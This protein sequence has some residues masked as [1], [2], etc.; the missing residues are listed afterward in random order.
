L[1]AAACWRTTIG[2]DLGDGTHVIGLAIRVAQGDRPLADEMNL[3]VLG[4]LPSVPFTW[5]WLHVVGTEGIVLASRLFYVLFATACAVVAWRAL[6]P[7]FG[8]AVP[9]VAVMAAAIPAPYNLTVVSYN[10]TP[11]SLLLVAASSGCAAVLARSRL[12]AVVSGVT[13]VLAAVAYPVM[14]VAALFTVVLVLMLSRSRVVIVPCLAG[15][16]V[17]VG[18]VWVWLA[19][20]VGLGAV[21]ST[22]DF[23]N[24]YQAQRI[25]HATRLNNALEFMGATMTSP[26]VLVA[27]GLA[28]VA[29]LPML[30]PGWRAGSLAVVPLLVAAQA[31][32][33]VPHGFSVPTAGMTTGV[34]ALV[35]V[36]LLLVPTAVWSIQFRAVPPIGGG[37]LLAVAVL[38]ALA[39]VPLVAAMTSSSPQWGAVA[40]ATAAPLAAVLVTAGLMWRSCSRAL[41]LSAG[42]S[43]V[44]ILLAAHSVQPY[45]DLAPWHLRARAAEG[46]LAGIQTTREHLR[47]AKDVE[48]AVASCRRPGESLLAY[49]IPAAYVFGQGPIDTNI[50]WL[51]AFGSVN[52][53]GVRWIERTGREPT[54]VVIARSYLRLARQDWASPTGRDPLLRWMSTHYRAVEQPVERIVVL[55]RIDG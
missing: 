46:P 35:L 49:G 33:E 15:A 27:L 2:L 13:A 51:G 42:V 22:I 44:V 48:E 21:R 40:A 7:H 45:R 8:S 9:A 16:A 34:L 19:C 50:L 37:T 12:W 4:S 18:A 47:E 24:A 43:V 14:G 55:R 25:G 5:L 1:V 39:Q 30:S 6:S 38:P 54:C 17:V 3:Q 31:V 20:A 29:A 26:L 28:L 52:E 11:A 23:T 32:R 53:A 36:L 41:W 10:T